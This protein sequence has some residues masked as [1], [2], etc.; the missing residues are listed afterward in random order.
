MRARNT[1]CV[2][3]VVFTILVNG[4]NDL[5]GRF[6]ATKWYIRINRPLK[7]YNLLVPDINTILTH[8]ME[9][10]STLDGVWTDIQKKIPNVMAELLRWHMTLT[11]HW[12]EVVLSVKR[13]CQPPTCCLLKCQSSQQNKT[14]RQAIIWTNA[15]ILLIGSS[16]TNFSEILSEINTCSF[17]E[18]YLKTSSA[19]W[20]PLCL[21]LN[22]LTTLSFSFLSPVISNRIK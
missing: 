7:R 3:L 15:G 20:R 5:I 11:W 2:I 18:M 22:V 21:G 13:Q 19:K 9:T 16:G 14:R 10:S 17:K 8:L 6:Y 12:N 4:N 1:L